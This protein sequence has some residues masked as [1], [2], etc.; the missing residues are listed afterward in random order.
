MTDNKKQ[1]GVAMNNRKHLGIY[2]HIPF[3]LSKCNYCDFLSFPADVSRQE[4]YFY[5]LF[6][7]ID[8]VLTK[9]P[10]YQADTVF[11]GGG[12]PS[13]VEEKWIKQIMELIPGKKSEATIEVNPGTVTLEKLLAYKQSGIDR[14][15]IGLQSLDDEQLR[16]LG[17]VHNQADFYATFRAAREAGFSNINVDLMS[18]IPNQNLLS[19]QETLNQV[20]VLAP[21]HISAYGLIIEEGTPFYE[22]CPGLPS[23]EEDRDMYRTTKE[24][25]SKQGYQRYEISN[26]AKEGFECIHNL[27]Y[28]QRRNYI[29]FGLG[30]A[31]MIDN[32]RF[33]N[34]EN[35]EQ[36]ISIC[37]S[38]D[39]PREEL[40]V[41]SMKEQQEE[42]MFLGLRMMK[43]INRQEFHDCFRCRP[44][45]IY[46][47][48]IE[49]MA[50]NGLV[51]VGE[52]IRLTE[53]GI[54]VSNY[55]LA[56][57]LQD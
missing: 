50:N 42:Y 32:V 7:E 49:K 33:K 11:I 12:T 28:W 3:C 46:G 47:H 45:E 26:Y 35:M 39:L 37:K 23:E 1:Q 55:V 44:E 30:A 2:I 20:M 41:L 54:D 10:E 17:R 40:Q 27:G 15:S 22:S 8:T 56:D 18:G 36:Y 14:L 19:W 5:A 25:L 24:I 53:E 43:G 29:G 9:H 57:F 21:E 13:V 48:V 31:S 51:E 6:K 52:N 16:I 4:E 38:G 34:T